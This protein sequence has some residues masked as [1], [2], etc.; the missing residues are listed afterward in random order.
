MRITEKDKAHARNP[1]NPRSRSK[2]S[3]YLGNE[4]ESQRLRGATELYQ[5][6]ADSSAESPQY[7]S[8]PRIQAYLRVLPLKFHV[9][10]TSPDRAEHK[11]LIFKPR[12]PQGVL[13]P[14]PNRMHHVR[15]ASPI[16]W[17]CPPNRRRRGS[18]LGLQNAYA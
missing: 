7:G 15:I 16:A 14:A 11:C 1:R 18:K 5:T 4:S 13:N 3:P 9:G 17:R 8:S 10:H 6:A 12:R 2:S